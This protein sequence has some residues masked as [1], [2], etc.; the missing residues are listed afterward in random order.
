MKGENVMQRRE[1]L[2]NGLL[3]A[4]AGLLPD[5]GFAQPIEESILSEMDKRLFRAIIDG[6]AETVEA[7]IRNGASVN[8]RAEFGWTPLHCA[9]ACF[10]KDDV[11][12]LELLISNGADLNTNDELGHTPL[13][14]AALDGSV[15]LVRFLIS[16][17]A[18]VHA[19]DEFGGTPFDFA[20]GWENRPVV[21]YL[22]GIRID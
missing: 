11:T 2:R 14:Y 16:N 19:E 5:I 20:K 18:D 3:L 9:V 1:F 7:L 15:E 10:R 12:I 4:S 6:K 17:G 8:I 21:E 13:H 22:A